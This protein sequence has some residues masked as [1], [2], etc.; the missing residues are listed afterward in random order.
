[1]PTPSPRLGLKLPTTADAFSTQDIH[2]NWD[3]L[4]DYPGI[5]ICTSGT[6]PEWGA[7]QAGMRIHETNTGLDWRWDGT[8]FLRTSPMGM[9]K[10][11]TG[12]WARAQRTTDFSTT[13]QTY[14]VAVS[15][16]NVV[17]PAGNRTLQLVVTFP[18]AENSAGMSAIA[19][20]RSVT[21]NTGTQE[22]GWWASGDST[23][24]T[25][26]AQGQGGTFIAWIP[27]GLA[28]GTYSWSVQLRASTAGGTSILR[29][30]TTTPCELSVI[31]V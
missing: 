25:A 2:D 30:G 31:E 10:T 22:G 29:A 3:L 28:A 13:S 12:G 8:Q 11:T 21:A 7:A 4:D 24:P 1:M 23:N 5:F 19:I 20:F 18:R 6:R 15:L 17:V 14:V 27:G 26:G 16:S 9:L